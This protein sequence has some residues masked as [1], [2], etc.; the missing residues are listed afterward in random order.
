MSRL[1]ELRLEYKD[2][3]SVFTFEEFDELTHS[4]TI[5][6]NDGFGFLHDGIKESN[7][8]PWD[9]DGVADWLD[10]HITADAFTDKDFFVTWYNK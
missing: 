9:E 8:S 10:E 2:R 7:I 5:T 6:P 4:G 1:E 3:G